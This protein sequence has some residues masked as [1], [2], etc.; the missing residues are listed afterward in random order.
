MARSRIKTFRRLL[1]AAVGAAL[2]YFFDPSRGRARRARTKDQAAAALRRRQRQAESQR[3]Y[4]EGVRQGEE[5]RA[6]GAGTPTPQDDVTLKNE[7]Q[8]ALSRLPFG[9]EDVTVEVVEGA[10]TLRGQLPGTDEM[11]QL[12]EAVRA[13]PGVVE[14]ISHLH[15]PEAAAPNKEPSLEAASGGDGAAIE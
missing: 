1:V 15:L 9:T 11:Q 2:A 13:V 14:V 10:V 6:R 3:R 7:V 8:A 12:Q 4:E 5:A